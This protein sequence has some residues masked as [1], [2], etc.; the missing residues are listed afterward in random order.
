[1]FS[2][3]WDLAEG[4]QQFHQQLIL[5]NGCRFG[6]VAGKLIHNFKKEFTNEK[7]LKDKGEIKQNGK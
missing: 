6:K 5:L 1:M 3:T 2:G 7:Y 4:L